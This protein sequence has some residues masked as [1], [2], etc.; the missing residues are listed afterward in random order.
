VGMGIFLQFRGINPFRQF[1]VT[2]VN[3]FRCVGMA[4][5]LIFCALAFTLLTENLTVYAMHGKT[6]AQNVIQF[7]LD[8]AQRSDRQAMI[9]TGVLAVVIAPLVEETLFRGRA[10]DGGAFCSDASESGGAAGA[11]RAGALPDGGL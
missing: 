5:G 11:L 10:G 3:V 9:L 1:G 4:V 2:R 7:F 6:D 8:A